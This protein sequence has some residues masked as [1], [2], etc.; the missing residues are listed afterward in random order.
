LPVLTLVLG[1]LD[2]FNPCSFW[3]LMML[4]TVLI[5]TGEKKKIWLVGG[6]FVVFSMLVYF[7]FL[8]AWFNFFTI[9]GFLAITKILVGL[10]AVVAGIYFLR[11]YWLRSKFVCK[12][13]PPKRQK[14]II[15]RIEKISK[16]ES[17]L[18]ILIG[19]GVLAFT[20]NLVELFCTIGLPA[21]Y[22]RI[23]TLA[24]LATWKYYLYLI[25][26][27]FLYELDEIVIVAVAAL[28]LTQLNLTHKYTKYVQL[29]GGILLIILGAIL[30][31]KPELLFFK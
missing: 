9:L 19:V 14:K 25:A 28:T 1:T 7:F 27:V 8:A 16:S 6:S 23:L 30:A 26:Y 31:I 10:L 13:I 11:D 21:I 22:T 3:A 20:V 15:S 5:A 2:G 17:L 24:S 18:A 4:I 29:V 12:I